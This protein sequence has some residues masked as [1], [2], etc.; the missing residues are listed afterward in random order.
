LATIAEIKLFIVDVYVF[1]G[2]KLGDE[3]SEGNVIVM[4]SPHQHQSMIEC[5]TQYV[6]VLLLYRLF[7]TSYYLLQKLNSV[8]MKK[9]M[10]MKIL[11]ETCMKV[12][13]MNVKNQTASVPIDIH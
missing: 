7:M 1:L 2:I 3:E 10:K 11:Y 4:S 8:K 6:I 12:F 13:L 5:V 9:K